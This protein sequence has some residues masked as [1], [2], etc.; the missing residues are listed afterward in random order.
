MATTWAK[1]RSAST[2]GS[3]ST[4]PTLPLR[5]CPDEA[6]TPRRSSSSGSF[7][8]SSGGSPFRGSGSPLSPTAAAAA[9]AAASVAGHL[10]KRCSSIGGGAGAMER[11]GGGSDCADLMDLSGEGGEGEAEGEGSGGTGDGEGEGEGS[12]RVSEGGGRARYRGRG[13]GY[14]L[15]EKGS[16]GRCLRRRCR[17]R[18]RHPL[19]PEGE[20]ALPLGGL[21][22]G[23][24][25]DDD[26]A[27]PQH[28]S[29]PV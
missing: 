1:T 11:E 13:G 20:G 17:R 6:T 7:G 19:S 21:L 4:T 3:P 26:L 15:V 10:G 2:S 8:A 25:G 9:V 16:T 27:A 24:E 14:L 28:R 23:F 12:R 22:R 29:S 18:R 5:I